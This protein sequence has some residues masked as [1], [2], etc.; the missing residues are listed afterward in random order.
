MI[1]T[2]AN[3]EHFTDL[4]ILFKQQNARCRAAPGRAGARARAVVARARAAAARGVSPLS[5]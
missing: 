2:T 5:A 1:Y 4:R 3:I